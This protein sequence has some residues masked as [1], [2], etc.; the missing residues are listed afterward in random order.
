VIG[1][2]WRRLLVK[3]DLL[4]AV[5]LRDGA[6]LRR[7]NGRLG[8]L[9]AD[10][11][12]VY[13]GLWSDAARELG[14]EVEDPGAGVVEVRWGTTVA[15][16]REEIVELDDPR[17]TARSFD[18][19][20]VHR[21]LRS[22]QVPVPDH[23]E[24]RPRD[25][26]A[27]RAFLAG[28][29][30]VV[31]PARDTG[32]GAGVTG[33]V[34]TPGQLRRAL[35][36][37]TAWGGGAMLERQ[38]D[39]E[40]YRLLFLDGE[41]LDVIRRRPPRVTGDGHASIS[42][43]ITAENRRR[44]EARGRAGLWFLRVDYDSIF[45]LARA[46]LSPKSVPGRGDSVMVKTTTSQNSSEENETVHAGISPEL[47]AECARAADAVGLRLAG[48]DVVGPAL[49]RSLSESGGA[50]IEVNAQ[51]GLHHH[52]LVADPEVATPVAVPILRALL[53]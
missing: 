40:V 22:A 48:I 37:A 51:P 16:V 11:V 21:L 20:L 25:G 15:R 2:A 29:R 34:E 27:A 42:R 26:R 32:V 8:E 49:D 6:S 47:T 19:P 12:R 24:I 18:K 50:V 10:R 7:V 38:V 44:L 36:G 13:N 33:G 53:G 41:L 9:R 46:G 45:E 17:A 5:G 4:F 39:G 23:L 31:K 43:L 52:Y 14:A 28:G 1:S 30:C 3:G 35:L